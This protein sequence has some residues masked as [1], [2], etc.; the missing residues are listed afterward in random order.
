[1]RRAHNLLA[2]LALALVFA[3]GCAS[4][5][6]RTTGTISPRMTFKKT[7]RL[8]PI[9][10]GFRSK[11]STSKYIKNLI[12]RFDG[13]D[14]SRRREALDEIVEIGRSSVQ[15][16]ESA[17]AAKS[18]AIREYTCLAL[19][20]ISRMPGSFMFGKLVKQVDHPDLRVKRAA[21]FAIG[22]IG[23]RDKA[24]AKK[25][26]TLLSHPDPT[27]RSYAAECIRKLRYWP[28]IPALIFNHLQ[29]KKKAKPKAP[30]KKAPAKKGAK[31]P[32]TVAK[33]H[34]MELTNPLRAYA[35]DALAHIT[36]VD[37]GT[38]FYMWRK[39]WVYNQDR[40]TSDWER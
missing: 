3:G 10:S 6:E 38:N 11:Q 22:H 33:I 2:A 29:P 27:V 12:T 31:R 20:R 34:G 17:L 25:V 7:G 32:K 23:T 40:Y 39:W 30:P 16:L 35:A 1:M 18:P 28:A 15:Y 24:V 14:E 26:F 19:G 21:C 4:E 5:E 36:H 13:I 9:H 37:Y 8:K